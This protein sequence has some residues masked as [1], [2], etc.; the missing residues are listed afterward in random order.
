MEAPKELSAQEIYSLLKEGKKVKLILEPADADSLYN[1]L[2]VIK[3]RDKKLFDD[4]GLNFVNCVIRMNYQQQDSYLFE[5]IKPKLNKK[6]SAFI[7]E[8]TP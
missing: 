6:Y 1:Y 2:A 4:L 5:L 3:S 8:G 7:I